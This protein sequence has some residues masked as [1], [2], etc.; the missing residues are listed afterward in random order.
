[1]TYPVSVGDK[2]G[3]LTVLRIEPRGPGKARRAYC[4]CDCGREHDADAPRLFHGKTSRCMRCACAPYHD[5]M[6]AHVR[7]QYINYRGGAA[8]RGYDHKLTLD[9]FRKIYLSD[10]TYCG[11]SPAK[12]IDRQDNSIGYLI[13]NCVPCCKHCNLAKR[14][15]AESEFLAWAA[16]IAVK[17]G[18]SL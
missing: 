5:E 17:Q 3:A 15:M 1:M 16:R 14:D 9:E 18:F 8:R 6:E 13:A 10:C 2:F 7:R 4:R 11:Q 12:G